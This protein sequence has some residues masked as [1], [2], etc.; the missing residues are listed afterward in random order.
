[1]NQNNT[2]HKK[3]KAQ[4]KYNIENIPNQETIW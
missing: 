3:N 2:N 4:M 1:M